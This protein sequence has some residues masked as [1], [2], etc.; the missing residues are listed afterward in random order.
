MATTIDAIPVEN[1]PTFWT[2]A[3]PE[4]RRRYGNVCGYLGMRIHEATGAATVDHFVP[5]SRDRRLAYEWSNFRLAA[6]QV[7]TNKGDH[8]DVLDPFE[9][10]D[11]WFT[12]DVASFEI[13][14]ADDL[15]AEVRAKV[16]ATISRLGLNDPVFCDA[17]AEYHD[18]YHGLRTDPDDP[19]EPWPLSWLA[20]ECPLVARQLRRQGRLRAEGPG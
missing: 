4:L 15:E 14:P 2:R 8:E 13:A 3:L 18:R 12:L 17:R 6:A 5:K 1:L 11:H 10:Q 19:P 20:C 9:V 7:N 16:E